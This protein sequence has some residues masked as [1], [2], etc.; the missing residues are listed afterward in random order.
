[1]LITLGPGYPQNSNGPSF[2]KVPRI[3]IANFFLF[4]YGTLTPFETQA[5][6]PGFQMV[7][8]QSNLPINQRVIAQTIQ[9]SIS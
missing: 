5:L 6:L 3:S 2:E 4:N 7:E 9:R 1:M 8:S